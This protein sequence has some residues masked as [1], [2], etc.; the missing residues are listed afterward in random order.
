[1]FY[2]V[3]ASIEGGQRVVI[4]PYFNVSSGK[5]VRRI[6]RQLEAA[7]QPLPPTIAL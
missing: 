3:M 7:R 5:G 1:V 2:V 6:K 4:A